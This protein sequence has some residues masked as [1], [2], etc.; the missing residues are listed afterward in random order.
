MIS[1]TAT[2]FAYS[3]DVVPDLASSSTLSNVTLDELLTH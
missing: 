3:A 1:A 2:P